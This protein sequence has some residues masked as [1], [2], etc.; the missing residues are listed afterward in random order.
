ML[1]DPK[2]EQKTEPRSLANLIAW[3]ERQPDRKIYDYT[4]S[5]RCLIAQWLQSSGEE[6]FNLLS[7]EVDALF[8]GNG[9]KIVTPEP[10]TFG[11]AL[12][13]AREV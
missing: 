13:R 5:E 10:W 1:Y 3:L 8:G 2:W 9:K 4:M 6:N 7:N 11:A 12:K